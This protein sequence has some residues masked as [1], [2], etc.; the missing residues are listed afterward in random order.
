MNYW[1]NMDLMIIDACVLI[2][3][4][5]CVWSIDNDIW[6][7]LC[8]IFMSLNALIWMIGA[9]GELYVSFWQC[10]TYIEIT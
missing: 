10:T 1:W 9:F 2:Y 5:V 6:M 3:E 4:Y 7:L 8:D